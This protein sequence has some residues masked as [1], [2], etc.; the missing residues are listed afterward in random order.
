MLIYLLITA[1]T[2]YLGA[3]VRDEDTDL[4][5]S[6]MKRNGVYVYTGVSRQQVINL[7]CMVS[8]FVTLFGISALRINVGND[9]ARYVNFMHLAN[10][11]A[12]VPTEAGF[13]YLTRFI[14]FIS[15]YE[16]FLLVFACYGFATI[17]LFL[18]AIRKLSASF[19][20]TFFM[21]M[22]L[23]YYFQSLSTMRY[24]LALAASVYAMYLILKGDYPAFVLMIL[25]GS[26]F[27]KSILLV[28]VL[29]PLCN[30][31]W[32]KYIKVAGLCAVI[33]SLFLKD[34]YLKLFL[35]VYPTYENTD[36]LTGGTSLI[37]IARCAM[38]ILLFFV[39]RNDLSGSKRDIFYLKL[40]IL[41]LL[42]YVFG[43]FLPVISRIGYYLTIS[44]IFIIPDIILAAG[45]GKRKGVL[46]IL[47]TLACI[48]YFL[49]F[50]F[51]QA[52]ADGVR[53][54]P[55]QTWL[56]HD[57]VPIEYQILD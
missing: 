6:E 29:Y 5:S 14:Y 8:I 36:F 56:F 21:F 2:I 28:L 50:I 26:L 43:S 9:Y 48:A 34:L 4:I 15:G 31:K 1:V 13:N 30:I 19:G 40:N 23:T 46:R 22:T 32:N 33:S 16:N 3:L 55:Y 53:I 54:L 27:H 42:L 18:L 11:H 25:A 47:V 41:A 39:F 17:A 38:V 51:R 20:W 49:I 10:V 24:Y 57:M 44:Q 7:I 35:I 37:S 12:Y 52:P 45:A